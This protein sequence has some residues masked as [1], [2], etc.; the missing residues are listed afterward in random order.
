VNCP[1]MEL[2]IP[3][4]KGCVGLWQTGRRNCA[5]A[6]QPRVRAEGWPP[7]RHVWPTFVRA[8]TA[9]RVGQC[10]GDLGQSGS[11][12]KQKSPPRRCRAG[13]KE[14]FDAIC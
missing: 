14:A 13:R 10:R 4:C 11:Y 9:W 2:A 6:T 12:Q 8:A 7:L 5:A 1:D 3:I